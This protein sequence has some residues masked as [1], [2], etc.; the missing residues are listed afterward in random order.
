MILEAQDGLVIEGSMDV[1]PTP[2]ISIEIP[3]KKTDLLLQFPPRKWLSIDIPADGAVV[4]GEILTDSQVEIFL[5]EHLNSTVYSLISKERI[6]TNSQ[7]GLKITISSDFKPGKKYRVLAM[8]SPNDDFQTSKD[9]APYD[10][11][12]VK[13]PGAPLPHMGHL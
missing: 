7:G 10:F 3:N 6:Q 4:L 9:E 11:F 2:K 8:Q 5:L 12:T 1:L 13:C